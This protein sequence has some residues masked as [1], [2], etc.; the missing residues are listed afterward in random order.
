MSFSTFG[1]HVIADFHGVTEELLNDYDFLRNAL[2]E[3]AHACGATVVGE[4]FNKFEPQGVTGVL[5]LAESHLSIH[6]YPEHG[7]CA[8]D[9]Y[10]CGTEV[11]PE[12]AYRHLLAVLKP[13]KAFE[14]GLKRGTGEI[15]NLARNE[16]KVVNS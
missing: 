16:L 3:A 1:R 14:R 13:K 5:V 6:T 7:F 10:T 11:D 2:Y 4:Q 15:T 9:C 12:K 8:I